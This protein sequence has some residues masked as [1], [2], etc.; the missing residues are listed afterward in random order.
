MTAQ[1]VGR[2]LRLRHAHA[3]SGGSQ[4]RAVLFN[5]TIYSRLN[6]LGFDTFHLQIIGE[7]RIQQLDFLVPFVQL[8][9]GQD[10]VLDQCIALILALQLRCL[11]VGPGRL[12]KG[13]LRGTIKDLLRCNV[14]QGR[15]GVLQAQ[16]KS[17]ASANTRAEDYARQIRSPRFA[18][19]GMCLVFD[20]LGCRRAAP[21]SQFDRLVQGDVLSSCSTSA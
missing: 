5:R 20:G 17:I 18:I 14:E 6:P 9:I 2:S 15:C 4:L 12:Y 19:A 1:N 21:D 8:N 10:R 7:L 3:Y 13:F 11:P 16:R